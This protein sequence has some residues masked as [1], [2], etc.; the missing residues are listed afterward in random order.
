MEAKE[1]HIYIRIFQ[2]LTYSSDN[3]QRE[4]NSNTVVDTE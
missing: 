3:G 1:S 2:S 4:N